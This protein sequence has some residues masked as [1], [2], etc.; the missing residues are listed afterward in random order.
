MDMEELDFLVSLIQPG[1]KILDVGCSNGYIT[2][3]IHDRT[4]AS[5]LGIDFSDVAI[6]QA[7]KRTRGKAQ[8]L[9]FECVDLTK[10]P[11]P[12]DEFGYIILIDSIYF[13]GEFKDSLPHFAERLG[14]AG[15]M[16]VSLFQIKEEGDPDEIFL[17]DH[18]LLAQALNELGLAYR[19]YD[20]TKNVRTHG[21]RNYQ[22]AEELKEA[23]LA[24]GN[25]FLFE[26]RRA[27][28]V[29]FKKAAENE[30]LVRFI[31]VVDG[32]ER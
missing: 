22:V 15:K 14:D 11:V 21:I 13:L 7:Q 10:E 17:P 20:F 18:T 9:R 31:Y 23:F 1:A 28:N 16:I 4:S 29:F 3:Y 26:A 24:E 5:L 27:E 2:E 32:L 19:W 12:G 25:G 6:E 8:T 30:E